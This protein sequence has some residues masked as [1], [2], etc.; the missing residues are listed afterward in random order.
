[1]LPFEKVISIG[2]IKT[3]KE[4]ITSMLHGAG[5][6]HGIEFH[7]VKKD[8]T[9]IDLIAFGSSMIYGGLPAI[10]GTIIDITERKKMEATIAQSLKEKEMLLKEIHHRVKNNMQVVSSLVSMQGRSI[11]DESVQALFSETQNRIQSIALVHEQLYRS[12]NISEIDYG[13]YLR[14]MFAPL[15]ESY[16]VDERRVS[17]VIDAPK[18]KITIEKAVPCSL[19]VNELLSNSLKHAFPGNRKGEI[20][21]GFH[22]DEITGDYV[23]DYRDNGVGIPMGLDIQ[24]TGSLGM[25]LV[26]GLTQQ[27]SGTISL[28]PGDGV[29]FKIVFPSVKKKV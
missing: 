11:K 5:G 7:G 9:I 22:L 6:G 19:I 23:L 10:Y 27:I 13:E 21:I 25:K 28:E 20:R 15:F 17:M 24:K 12:D 8:G 4:I 3:V 18:A 2:D 1:M 26:Y 14:K 16:N 29:H